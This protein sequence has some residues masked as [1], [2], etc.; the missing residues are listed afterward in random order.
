MSR[1]I[2]GF[3]GMPGAGKSEAVSIAKSLGFEIVSMGDVVREEA[4]KRG[5]PLEDSRIGRFATEER[6]KHGNDI[7]AKRTADKVKGNFIV[8]D[9]IRSIDEVE[10][11]RREFGKD[12][13]LIAIYT[14]GEERL[15]RILRRAREDDVR[16]MEE[17]ENRDER[18]LGWGIGNAIAKADIMIVNDSTLEDFRGRVKKML[19]K[20]K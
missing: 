8:I 1:A 5:I 16:N 10:S 18:E 14:K 11:F 17:L 7:W 15:Q 12:F 6:E 19:L 13:V 2:V 3:T 20:L 4:I 9:G